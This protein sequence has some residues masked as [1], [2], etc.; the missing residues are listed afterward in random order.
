MTISPAKRRIVLFVM[1]S[2]AYVRNFEPVLRALAAR[3][4]RTTVLFEGRKAG[5]DSAGLSL[6]D[7]LS[8]ELDG[9]DYEL[10]DPLPRG[11][12]GQVRICLEAGQDYL[13]YF[14]HPY[15]DGANRLRA[16]SVA[17]LP[18]RVEEAL[19]SMLRRWPRARRAL[20]SLARRI[21]DR[22]GEDR[23]VREQ[24]E[25]RRPEALIVTPM[26]QFRSR[27]G[28]WVRAAQGLGIGTMLCV[29]SWDN[30]TNKGLMHVQPDRVV[31][32]NE[33][34]RREAIELHG[35]TPASISIAGAWPY[36]R[37]F[38]WRTSRSKVELCDHLGLPAERAIVLY[39][40]S[41][42]FIA[43]RERPAVASWVRALRS[44]EDERL[45]TA[46]VI[47]RPHPLNGD[48]WGDGSLSELPGVAV[49]PPAGADPVED[50]SRAD[51]YDSIVHA[52][53]VVG[54]NTSALIESAILDRPALALPGPE[55]RSSQEDLPHFRLL[56]GER[57]M[58]QVSESI[59][60]HVAQLGL[61]LDDPSAGAAVRR[62][63]VDAFIRPDTSGASA[64]QRVVTALD[65]LT[66]RGGAPGANNEQTCG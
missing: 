26:V 48:E 31:V 5:G 6:I 21:N 63:F 11:L 30:L 38:G 14:D 18:A 53:A 16:R 2:P 17:F 41:S 34:Q 8:G 60:E 39:V 42:R 62:R 54:V 28:D 15:G 66:G 47:V 32:W 13:R 50:S 64:T 59:A 10:G 61:A 58:L 51:Y 4:D 56:V 9:L 40:C 33:A 45:A 22:L 24:L 43:E 27:Q 46:S 23:R 37:W 7:R 12:R 3:G 1:Q 57:G 52:D 35:A 36:D 20:S 19:A 65:D 55:F 29:H 25:R 44:S 49:F